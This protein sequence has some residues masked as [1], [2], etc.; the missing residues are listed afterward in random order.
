MAEMR[1]VLAAQLCLAV[2]QAFLLAPAQHVHDSDDPHGHEHETV[3]HSHFSFHS[4]M[5]VRPGEH[6]IGEPDEH[7]AWSLDTF[8]V[9][10]TAA[11]HPVLLSRAPDLSP[12][13]RTMTGALPLVEERAHDPPAHCPSIPRAPPA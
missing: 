1:P 13:F 2:F 7:A 5:P 10:L 8:T 12:R 4:M 3:I 11:A 6:S 9:V